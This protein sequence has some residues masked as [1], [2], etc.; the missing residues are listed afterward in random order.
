[1]VSE[2]VKPKD[3]ETI[4]KRRELLQTAL[5]GSIAFAGLAPILALAR[6]PTPAKAGDMICSEIRNLQRKRYKANELIFGEVYVRQYNSER[7][8]GF[9]TLRGP[10]EDV[11]APS[12]VISRTDGQ[13]IAYANDLEWFIYTTQKKNDEEIFDEIIQKAEKDGKRKVAR[14]VRIIRE[15]NEEEEAKHLCHACHLLATKYWKELETRGK[16]WIIND[17]K[18]EIKGLNVRVLAK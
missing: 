5:L 3:V 6:G 2:Q 13:V 16:E 12:V 9:Y 8:L 1:V 10:F 7:A 15:I 14:Y 11:F 18:K 17:L 4:I